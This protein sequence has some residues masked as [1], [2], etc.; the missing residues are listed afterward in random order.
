MFKVTKWAHKKYDQK[1]KGR[2]NFNFKIFKCE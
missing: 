1:K 2:V